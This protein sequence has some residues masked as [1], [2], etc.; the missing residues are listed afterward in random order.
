MGPE[1]ASGT[2]TEEREAGSGASEGE[3]ACPQAG[4]KEQ[5]GSHSYGGP[6]KTEG[7]PTDRLLLGPSLLAPHSHRDERAQAPFRKQVLLSAFRQ[8]GRRGG[9]SPR[10]F[11]S[12]LFLKNGQLERTVSVPPGVLGAGQSSAAAFSSFHFRY[13]GSLQAP[14]APQAGVKPAQRRAALVQSLVTA[15]SP[16][17]WPPDRKFKPG[18]TAGNS[19]AAK[20]E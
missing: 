12:L 7:K 18:D 16:G 13:S 14:Q 10:P 15:A 8:A 1:G 11:L 5:M 19:N 17:M 6:P 2:W 4:E 20:G 9:D 3:Q